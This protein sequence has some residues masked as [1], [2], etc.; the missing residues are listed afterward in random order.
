MLSFLFELW[1]ESIAQL[2]PVFVQILLKFFN[3]SI[4]HLSVMFTDISIRLKAGIYCWKNNSKYKIKWDM[5]CIC[6][7]KIYSWM[8]IYDTYYYIFFQWPCYIR[9]NAFTHIKRSITFTIIH[10][11]VEG[12]I[13]WIVGVQEERKDR[14]TS[15][16]PKKCTEPPSSTTRISSEKK[17]LL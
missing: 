9:L 3:L 15:I 12:T 17:A 4:H 10:I 13:Q 6:I 16:C 14:L 2:R 8:Y 7:K 1:M 5:I 11:L